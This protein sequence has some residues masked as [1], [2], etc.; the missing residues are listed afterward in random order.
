M[1]V[2]IPAVVDAQTWLG[3]RPDIIVEHLAEEFP[4]RLFHS[5]HL[6]WQTFALVLP[7]VVS[8]RDGPESFRSPAS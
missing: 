1:L 2:V 4:D 5:N 8:G 3:F 7:R 6:T